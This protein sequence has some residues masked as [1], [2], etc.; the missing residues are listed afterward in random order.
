[1]ARFKTT[2]LRVQWMK[3][4]L[5]FTNCSKGCALQQSSAH[6][7]FLILIFQRV[8]GDEGVTIRF[9]FFF[10]SNHTHSHRFLKTFSCF[11]FYLK[12]CISGENSEPEV[13]T[14]YFL[15]FDLLREREMM[16]YK[17]VM[18]SQA[19]LESLWNPSKSTTCKSARL[20]HTL[21]AS[22]SESVWFI[23]LHKSGKVRFAISHFRL[24]VIC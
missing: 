16:L 3:K 12:T 15:L 23:Q 13:G 18:T 20:N 4:N 7:H 24:K 5:N 14:V 11:F 1:M 21:S 17:T 6:A 9:F 2:E 19:P 10:I 22:L 8:N